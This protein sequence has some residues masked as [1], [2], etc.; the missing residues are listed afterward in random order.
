MQG[1]A[2]VVPGWRKYENINK[3]TGCIAVS[4]TFCRV[5]ARAAEQH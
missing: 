3:I 5:E 2:T 1:G 4:K